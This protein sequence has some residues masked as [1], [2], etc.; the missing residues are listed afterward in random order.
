MKKLAASLG[1]KLFQQSGR[2]VHMTHAG[3]ELYASVHEVFGQL[4]QLESRLA[5]L[6][7]PAIRTSSQESA[8]IEQ[9]A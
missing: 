4:G 5:P 7:H 6:R 1:L 3:Q 8:L 2:K 9:V